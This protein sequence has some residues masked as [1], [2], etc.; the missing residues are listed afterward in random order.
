MKY[1]VNTVSR[2]HVARGVSGGFTQSDHGR[3]ARIA[4]LEKGDWMVFYSPR[5]ADAMRS[6]IDACTFPA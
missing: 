4:K 3:A 2:D 5:T 1:W 6:P